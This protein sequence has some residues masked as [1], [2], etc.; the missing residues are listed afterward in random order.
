MPNHDSF[1]PHHEHNFTA[2][3]KAEVEPE[4]ISDAEPI[5][6]PQGSKR[7]SVE[8]AQE[9]ISNFTKTLKKALGID[10]SGS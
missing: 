6:L 4:V 8:N 3:H 5:P 10:Q 7:F 9:R 1:H 2:V